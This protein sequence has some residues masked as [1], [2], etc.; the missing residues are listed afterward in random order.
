VS[1]GTFP[2]EFGGGFLRLQESLSEYFSLCS[3]RC[4]IDWHEAVFLLPTLL[5]K[6]ESHP[7]ERSG[8]RGKEYREE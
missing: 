4:N 6:N 8:E 5:P 1:L 7:K 2:T 3:L